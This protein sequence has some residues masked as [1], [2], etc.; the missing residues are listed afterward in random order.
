[1][2]KHTREIARRRRRRVDARKNNKERLKEEKKGFARKN[3]REK[4]VC[5]L[6]EGVEIFC[7]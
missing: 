3:H 4:G 2:T 5:V 1:V 7:G 6:S